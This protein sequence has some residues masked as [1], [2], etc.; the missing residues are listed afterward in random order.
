MDDAGSAPQERPVLR[1]VS[2][3]PTPEDIAALVAVVAAASA[4]G[5]DTG[6]PAV[7]SEWAERSRML[8]KPLQ[9]GP[10]AWWASGLPS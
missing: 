3:N 6:A 8:R 7:P 10:H 4:G 2:G 1:V 9:P 5:G